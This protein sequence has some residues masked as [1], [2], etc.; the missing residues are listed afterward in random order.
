MQ[1]ANAGCHVPNP[2]DFTSKVSMNPHESSTHNLAASAIGM[3]GSMTGFIM[4]DGVLKYGSALVGMA[5]GLATIYFMYRRDQ[6]EKL[7]MQIFL[8][9]HEIG[10]I[11][12]KQ[13]EASDD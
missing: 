11:A 5:V 7:K 12:T 8:A 4:S 13:K 10:R 9:E 6:R 1:I 2:S 3:L